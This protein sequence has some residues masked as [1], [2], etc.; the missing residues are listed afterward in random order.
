M[1]QLD[2]EAGAVLA[3][4]V[5]DL[6]TELRLQRERGHRLAQAIHPFGVTVV[7]MTLAA[8]AGTI[9]Q[10]N[11]HGPQMSNYWDV[12]RIQCTGF[13][14]GTVTVYLNVVNAEIAA[15]FSQAGVLLNGKAQILLNATDTLVFS[16]TGITGSVLVSLAGVEIAADCI[17]EYLK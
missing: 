3:A 16:A 2:V 10:P 14:A 1:T 13:T 6:A 9:N 15:V 4:S 17:G 11:L 7:S 5:S 12:K 8:G